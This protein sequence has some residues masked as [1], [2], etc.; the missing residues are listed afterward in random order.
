MVGEIR[1]LEGWRRAFYD[2]LS[3]MPMTKAMETMLNELNED[4]IIDFANDEMCLGLVEVNL[5][6]QV[7]IDLTADIN[8]KP[9]EENLPIIESPLFDTLEEA[10]SWYRQ[11]FVFYSNLDIGMLVRAENGD[12]IDSWLF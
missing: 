3:E 8:D 7:F 12:I 2:A 6:Y 1:D 5:R 10:D 4:N 11:L 9:L